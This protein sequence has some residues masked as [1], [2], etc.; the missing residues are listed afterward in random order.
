MCSLLTLYQISDRNVLRHAV[1][2][3][4]GT[5]RHGH[6]AKVDKRSDDADEPR[7]YFQRHRRCCRPTSDHS[8]GYETPSFVSNEAEHIT[9]AILQTCHRLHNEGTK[10]LYGCN[11]FSFTEP[12]S[13]QN[14]LAGRTEAQI[15][16]MQSVEMSV[17][18]ESP[19][20]ANS[21]FVIPKCRSKRHGFYQSLCSWGLHELGR[22]ENLK[23]IGLYYLDQTPLN[24]LEGRN[25]QK[26]RSIK[27]RLI[28]RGL[29]AAFGE[30]R[31]L[32][33]VKSPGRLRVKVGEYFGPINCDTNPAVYEPR[34]SSSF[35]T[36]FNRAAGTL[37]DS[38]VDGLAEEFKAELVSPI[39]DL[40]KIL[41][42]EVINDAKQAELAA[43]S[44]PCLELRRQIQAQTSIVDQREGERALY[45]GNADTY[46]R[47][48]ARY[49]LAGKL[50]ARAYVAAKR[51]HKAQ[52]YAAALADIAKVAAV[53]E[54]TGLQVE[55]RTV[56]RE[57]NRRVDQT[58]WPLEDHLHSLKVALRG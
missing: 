50:D 12:S 28:R 48:M 11:T 1:C 46:R 36:L 37:G 5:T 43:I 47:K 57:I 44:A 13:F 45:Q 54:R 56:M 8:R 55:L 3:A 40:Q 29:R 6:H 42:Q 16:V 52:V 4:C 30:L 15:S 53:L 10:I 34:D 39:T 32:D 23:D 18:A 9:P 49:E 31:F 38:E 20:S 25:I 14:F 2:Q 22:L 24:R 19:E 51:D 7:I 33:R 17:T 35:E 21:L 41:H 27:T 58:F 26:L